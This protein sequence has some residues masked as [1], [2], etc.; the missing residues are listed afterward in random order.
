MNDSP[1]S[2]TVLAGALGNPIRWR[3]L[4]ELAAGAPLLTIELSER[5]GMGPNNLSRHLKVLLKAGLV[6][7]NRAGQYAIPPQRLV[8]K[9]ERTLDY[10]TCLLRLGGEKKS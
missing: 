5:V 9:E 1:L 4:Q 10:G 3:A 2:M 8:S 6:T 7:Q